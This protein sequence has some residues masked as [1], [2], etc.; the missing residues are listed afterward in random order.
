M[1]VKHSHNNSSS[2]SL[3][4]NT[5]SG[6]LRSLACHHCSL[7]DDVNGTQVDAMS[8]E[9]VETSLPIRECTCGQEERFFCPARMNTCMLLSGQDIP[10]CY[11]TSPFKQAGVVMWW[12][13]QA[14][15]FVT[16]GILCATKQGRA[17]LQ[18]FIRTIYPRF[19]LFVANR[20]L[21]KDPDQATSMIRDYMERRQNAIEQRYQYDFSRHYHGAAV[22]PTTFS[23]KPTSLQLKTHTYHHCNEDTDKNEDN[24]EPVECTI[25][26]GT[27]EDGDRVGSLP[28][29]HIFHADCLKVWLKSRNVCPLCLV[30]DVATP[31]FE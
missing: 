17:V 27:M 26:F 18:F 2:S 4:N 20:M 23:Q 9:E 19:N 3:P 14:W 10:I 21:R 6:R 25:C 16:I 12:V 5:T 22:V 15:I 29:R 24:N 1:D 31:C 11:H 8:S 30:E 7:I 13:M 28:C